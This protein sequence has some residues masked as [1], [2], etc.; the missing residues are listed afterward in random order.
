VYARFHVPLPVDD[1]LTLGGTASAI[2]LVASA[3]AT[4]ALRAAR[5]VNELRYE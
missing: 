4:L 1:L 3:L 2:V 5:G